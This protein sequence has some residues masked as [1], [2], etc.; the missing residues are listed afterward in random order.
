MTASKAI[1]VQLDPAA[2][3]E[4]IVSWLRTTVHERL[5]KRGAVVGLS[6]GIDSSTVVH[7]CQRAFGADRVIGLL[8]PERDSSGES[9][10]LGQ[11]VADQ[12]GIRTE[13]IDLTQALTALG[14]YRYR[15]EAIKRVFPEYDPTTHGA[16]IVLPPPRL[17]S[18]RL[19]F[20]SVAIVDQEGNEKRKRL[21]FA[22]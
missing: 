14:C 10:R 13:T 22:A 3:T 16:K 4:R 2:E 1:D 6:G 5:H 21:P 7:I 17:D 12:L 9:G 11:A 8:M 18:D 15:D 20:F 19:N